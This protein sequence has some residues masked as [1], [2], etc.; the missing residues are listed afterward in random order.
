MHTEERLN[1]PTSRGTKRNDKRNTEQATRRSTLAPALE[2]GNQ[3]NEEEQ[4]RSGGERFDQHGNL[5][6][7][8]VSQVRFSSG[9]ASLRG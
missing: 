8:L 3:S 9:G 5:L 1:S 4:D 2:H 6:L 7:E